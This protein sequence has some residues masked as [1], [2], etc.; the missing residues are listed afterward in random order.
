[1]RTVS[2]WSMLARE[3]VD[4]LSLELLKVRL[5][6][7]SSNLVLAHSREVGLDDLQRSLSTQTML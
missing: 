7:A 5:G 3:A 6:R 2:H 4:A 1:M